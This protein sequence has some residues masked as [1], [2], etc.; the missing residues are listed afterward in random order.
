RLSYADSPVAS[1]LFSLPQVP[2]LSISP[3]TGPVT[4][5]VSLIIS[6]ADPSA[7]IHYTTDG[8]VPTT[9][10]P[11]YE[12]PFVISDIRSI[13]AKAWKPGRNP[14]ELATATYFI[15]DYE[16]T[17]VVTLAGRAEAGFADG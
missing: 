13:N 3:P 9:N 15:V 14:S 6:C 7:E 4:N 8:T 2:V 12:A 11:L 17:V 10:S 5:G 16:P 1:V